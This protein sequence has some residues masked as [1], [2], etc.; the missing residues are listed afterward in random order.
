[1]ASSIIPVSC[2][3]GTDGGV[4]LVASGGVAPYLCSWSNGMTTQSI[5]SLG[6]G[7]YSV[8]LTDQNSCLIQLTYSI[9][10]PAISCNMFL[11]DL[12]YGINQNA[13]FDATQII[14]TAGNGTTYTIAN[15]ANISVIAGQKISCLPGTSINAGAYAHCYITGDGQFCPVLKNSEII[16]TDQFTIMG[17]TNLRQIAE[18]GFKV[19]PNPTTGLVTLDLSGMSDPGPVK[20]EIIGMC[21]EE[22]LS[23]NLPQSEKHTISLSGKPN[24]IYVLRLFSNSHASSVKIIKQ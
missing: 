1:V 11:D 3:G 8:T 22:V 12:N 24:G 6:A 5:T 10:Q 20:V 14:T 4:D 13:C 7:D 19:Y 21:S 18:N 9:P 17:Q 15:G 2:N 23:Q 16:S